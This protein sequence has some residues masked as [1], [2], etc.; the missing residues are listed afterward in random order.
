MTLNPWPLITALLIVTGSVSSCTFPKR[1]S[2]SSEDTVTESGDGAT[3]KPKLTPSATYSAAP[4]T[5]P[6]EALLTDTVVIPGE[7][8]GPITRTTTREDLTA[9]FGEDRLTDEAI[10]VGEGFTEPGTVIDLGPDQSFTIVWQDD[11]RTQ[12]ALMR[13]FG[14]AWKTPE[15]IGV[16][17]SFDQ[18]KTTL[19]SFKLYGF[20]WDYEGSLELEGSQFEKYH[21]NL[22][23]RVSPDAEA[24]A[25]NESAYQSFLGDSLFPS[26]QPNLALLDLK[27]DQMIVYLEGES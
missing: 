11:N 17:T 1:T 2:P 27:V 15:G 3:A 22:I 24:I 13:N 5:T 25:K 20:G 14:P 7:R 19:G 9:L 8:V 16:G 23:L 26:D 18:L 21:D 4:A 12:P 10:H 6:S